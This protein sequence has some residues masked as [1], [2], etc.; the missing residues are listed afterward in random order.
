MGQNRKET[1]S[2]RPVINPNKS[3]YIDILSHRQTDRVVQRA[4][5]TNIW[6]NVVW[7]CRH[8][9]I[10]PDENP[11]LNAYTSMFDCYAW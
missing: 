2:K 10:C 5:Y 6:L 7:G 11:S 1:I 8:S 4:T 3:I 9:H